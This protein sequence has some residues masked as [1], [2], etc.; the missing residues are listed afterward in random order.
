MNG[1]NSL[2]TVTLQ[3]NGNYTIR[4]VAQTDHIWDVR[5][6]SYIVGTYSQSG[7]G[8]SNQIFSFYDESGNQVTE[9]T[10]TE[11]PTPHTNYRF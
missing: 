3:Q 6:S 7:A 11:E 9:A 2:W 8:G 1:D 5:A 4:N 10:V